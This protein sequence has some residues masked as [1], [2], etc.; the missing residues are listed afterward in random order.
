MATIYSRPR[1]VDLYWASGTTT[2]TEIGGPIIG[3]ATAT[4]LGTYRLD[5]SPSQFGTPPARGNRRAGRRRPGQPGFGRGPE[6]GGSPGDPDIAVTSLDWRPDPV[7]TWSSDSTDAGGVDISYTIE[8]SPLPLAVPID[9][10]WADGT[11]LS[12]VLGSPITQDQDGAALLSGTAKGAIN[13]TSPPRPWG[14]R[15]PGPQTSWSWPTPP[16]DQDP[17]GLVPES[18]EG[19]NSQSLSTSASSILSDSVHVTLGDLVADGP[20]YDDNRRVHASRGGLPPAQNQPAPG[21]STLSQAEA[22]LE[23]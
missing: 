23:S 22:I 12:D 19:D 10:Y 5:A 2:D 6:Q 17:Y 15:P 16:T 3:A 8:G 18:D 14:I 21:S 4:A 11:T 9:L 1:T 20:E 13:F 7:S